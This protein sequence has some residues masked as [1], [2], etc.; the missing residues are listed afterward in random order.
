MFYVIEGG[1]I[2]MENDIYVIHENSYVLKSSIS[3][4]KDIIKTMNFITNVV[5][6]IIFSSENKFKACFFSNIG[7]EIQHN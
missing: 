4:L 2:V 1:F 7:I 3:V 6:G 5:K